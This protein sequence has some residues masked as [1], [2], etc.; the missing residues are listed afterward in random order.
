MNN[1]SVCVRSRCA[2]YE[3]TSNEKERRIVGRGVSQLRRR[4]GVAIVKVRRARRIG[5]K[6]R[7]GVD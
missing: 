6:S 4:R 3:P 5:N 7:G 1:E 2:E